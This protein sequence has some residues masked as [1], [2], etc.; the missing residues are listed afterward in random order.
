M[1][2]YK[3]NPLIQLL[4]LNTLVLFLISVY[5]L[6]FIIISLIRYWTYQTNYY[7]FGIFD[8]AIWQ[9]SRF[10]V[11]IIDKGE[12]GRI[13]FGDHFNPSMFLLSPLF[14]ITNRSEI[15][16][17]VQTVCV[18]IAAWIGFV[19]SKQV[20]IALV[21]SFLGFIGTQ[22]ALI[23]DIHDST[24]ATLPLMICFWAIIKKRWKLFFISL[25]IFTGFKES[26]AGTTIAL[27]VFILFAYRKMHLKIAISTIL[28]GIIWA[29]ISIKVIIPYFSG[30]IYDYQPDHLTQ[31]SDYITSIYN[32]PLK[33]NTILVSQATFGFLPLFF[34][35]AYPLMIEHYFTRFVLSDSSNR[36]D[37]GFH[38]NALLA[39]ILFISTLYTI[40]S[41]KNKKFQK[42]LPFYA[43]AIILF[44]G[45]YNRLVYHGPIDLVYN[46]AFY[47]QLSNV[48]YQNDFVE[49]FPKNGLVMTQNDLATRLTHG[50]SI[51]LLRTDYWKI[52]PD[53][54]ILNL[55]PGQNPNSY[56]P[57]NYTE[58]VELKNTLLEDPNYKVD[59]MHDEQY[60]FKRIMN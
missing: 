14:W 1:N 15:L 9:V 58:A 12:N 60:L 4:N 37:L 3:K 30:G 24:F 18:A 26:H 17:V 23:A 44:V 35:P 46:K 32:H 43:I 49:M 53:Y 5:T 52:N 2:Q 16:L 57:L 27:G 8:S 42:F 21:V 22:N 10:E 40:Q 33:Q 7:D 51:R 45:Y 6:S 54:I 56:T 28:L 36:W 48:S 47:Q 55:T 39:P 38:Y 19:I 59:K 31:S 29:V 50:P 41:I 20:R 13:I 11:P 25:I 34:P